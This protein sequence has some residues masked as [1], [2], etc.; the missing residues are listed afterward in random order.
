MPRAINVES[1]AR[2]YATDPARTCRY[3]GEAVEAGQLSL[4][5]VSIRDLFEALVEDGREVVRRMDPTRKSGGWRLQEAASA[6]DLSGFSNVTGQIIYTSIK[7]GFELQ[8]MLADMLCTTR[9][10]PFPYGEKVPGVGGVG[11]EAEVVAEGQPYPTV[12]MSEEYV[13][14][15]APRKR[16]FIVPVTREIVVFD[17]TGLIKDRADTGTKWMALNKEK[18]VLDVA[19]GVVNTYKR[20]G[21]SLNT[22]LTSGAYINS[23]SNALV[24][25]TDIENA[26]LLFDAITDPT[27]G[28][29]VSWQ[30]GMT[31]VVPT[32]LHRTA[33]RLVRFNEIRFNDGASGTTAYY[34]QNPLQDRGPSTG[35]L[36]QD[37]TVLTSA[38]VKS[39]TGSASTW[40]YGRPKEAFVYNEV[41]QVETSQAPTGNP[42]EFERDIQLQFKASEFGTPGVMEPRYVTKN[43]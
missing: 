19:F 26:E 35:Q 2:E 20:N 12:G 9:Q 36:S 16:G 29:P 14:F 10:S 31:L 3:L 8:T 13:E 37:I 24:D 4:K 30:G 17:R 6:V 41:W 25:W 7:K 32:A 27:T 21:T 42:A 15:P 28:E 22:Y 5:D 38:Y 18:R 23:Q 39:R 11:D 34:G 40:F 1:V 33:R 43:T